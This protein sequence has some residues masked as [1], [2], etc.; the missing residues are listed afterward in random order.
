MAFVKPSTRTN[1]S[2]AYNYKAQLTSPSLNYI[3]NQFPNIINTTGGQTIGGSL[4]VS[5]ALIVNGS[6]TGNGAITIGSDNIEFTD[7]ANSIT[8]FQDTALSTSGHQMSISA[9]NTSF[10]GGTGGELLLQAGSG[11]GASSIGGNVNIS[12][13]TGFIVDGEIIL[14]S[15]VGV[16]FATPNIAFDP[17]I[18][19]PLII[20]TSLAGSAAGQP[21]NIAAQNGGAAGGNG[22]HITISGGSAE[23]GN[24]NGGNVVAVVGD[25]SG[26]G[27]P[28]SFYVKQ[29][30]NALFQVGVAGMAV[31]SNVAA[32]TTGDHTL[33]V[34]EYISPWI[35]L[36]GTLSGHVNLIFPSGSGPVVWFISANA[37]NF[38]T[39]D[40]T[41]KCAGNTATT[42]IGFTST[43]YG[44]VV[45]IDA[46][47]K[48]IAATL[49]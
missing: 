33:S 18:V 41:F 14:T 38:N 8:I 20:Q 43:S 11:L 36:T 31:N 47:N 16:S 6:I 13:G 42:T 23:F 4:T 3:D 22:G 32:I 39:Y 10:T 45:M 34:A 2:G 40:V 48:V 9:Q 24:N 27:V 28:G 17:N 49:N 29:N 5:G 15:N 46:A 35:T 19:G 37:V 44:A 21:L 25:G 1:D 7:L 26:S 30:N 12:A